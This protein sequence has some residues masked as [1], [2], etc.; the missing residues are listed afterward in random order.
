MK[1]A[2]EI[3]FFSLWFLAKVLAERMQ[4]GSL[5]RAGNLK[6][7]YDGQSC[8]FLSLVNPSCA[9]S[10][11]PTG[12]WEQERWWAT[13]NCLAR[14]GGRASTEV[15][16]GGFLPFLS[17]AVQKE[18][19]TPQLTCKF[20]YK[21]VEML[22]FSIVNNINFLFQVVHLPVAFPCSGTIQCLGCFSSLSKFYPS[23]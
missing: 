1:T 2:K 19:V 9:Q 7:S 18:S 5:S 8:L 21:V 20:C 23:V 4:R 22:P 6:Y 14:A 11:L 10:L 12:A 3:N 16:T 17:K 13:A 15:H